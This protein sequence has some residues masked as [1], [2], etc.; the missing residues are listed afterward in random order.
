[1]NIFEAVVEQIECVDSLCIVRFDFKDTPLSMMSLDLSADIKVG[2]R[3]KLLAKATHVAIAKGFSGNISYSNQIKAKIIE[4][5]KG[6]LLASVLAESNGVVFESIITKNSALRM[7][8]AVD[9]AV[10]LFIKASELSI[11]EVCGDN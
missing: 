10:T 9:D 8:L 11:L 2:V 3:V 6:E 5:E 7:N 1:M 4:I